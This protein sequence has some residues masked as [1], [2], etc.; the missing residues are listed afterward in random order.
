MYQVNLIAYKYENWI[1]FAI[2]SDILDPPSNIAKGVLSSGIE[3]NKSCCRRPVVGSSNSFKLLLSSSVP[4]LKF[5]RFP[6][7]NDIFWS[8]FDT[9]C[10]FMVRIEDSRDK[11]SNEAGFANSSISNEYELKGVVKLGLHILDYNNNNKWG[12]INK[13]WWIRRF[14]WF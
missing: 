14:Y 11:P 6:I 9:N 4:D 10:K 12:Q 13:R 7:D 5:Y 2:I 1:F 8:K 3:N